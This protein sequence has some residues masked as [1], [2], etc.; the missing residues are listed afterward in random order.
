MLPRN[1][2]TECWTQGRLGMRD[3]CDIGTLH[4]NRRA[5]DWINRL[6]A[7]RRRYGAR[8]TVVTSSHQS[9][10]QMGRVHLRLQFAPCFHGPGQMLARITANPV[11][12][13]PDGSL[14]A[15]LVECPEES[16]DVE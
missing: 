15:Q 11:A 7:G 8:H 12:L 3:E 13:E 2:A 5:Q 10:L 9:V 4:V 16:S 1:V 6:T 14:V